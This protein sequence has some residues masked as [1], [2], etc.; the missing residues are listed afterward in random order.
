MTKGEDGVYTGVLTLPKGTM[1]R[2]KVMKST[3][4]G[5]SGG[6]NIWSA[7]SYSS[8]LNSHGT[9]DFGEFTNNLIPNGSFEDGD[10]K[11][12]P[13]GCITKRYY[14]I[15][16]GYLLVIGDQYPVSATSD[17]FVIPP[18]QNLRLSVYMYSWKLDGA[19]II[20][21]KDVDAQSVLFKNRTKSEVRLQLG[22][23]LRNVQ[24]RKF[25]GDGSDCLHEYRKRRPWLR[26]HVACRAVTATL[27]HTPHAI[28]Y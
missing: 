25:A 19:G 21:V 8:V 17:T 27:E 13:T 23:V 28:T 14:A 1:F 9:Y 6:I 2:L 12:T 11:W 24:D 22:C 16:G 26:Q 15:N 5:T 4:D 3:V 18:N 20:E 10:V 7:T